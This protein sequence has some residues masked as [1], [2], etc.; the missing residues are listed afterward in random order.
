MVN[1]LKS[2]LAIVGVVV[3]LALALAGCD[4]SLDGRYEAVGKKPGS[5]LLEVT[6]DTAI[7][8]V[9]GDPE[10]QREF[11]VE[12]KEDRVI[13]I[14]KNQDATTYVYAKSDDG[15]GLKCISQSCDRFGSP[16]VEEWRRID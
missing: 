6:G 11:S 1:D 3:P 12:Q 13:F 14:R 16:L 5:Y 10:S 8:T 9:Y 7:R 15:H 4:K 2:K